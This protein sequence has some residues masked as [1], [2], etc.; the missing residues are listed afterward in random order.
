M[1]IG[2]LGSDYVL[3]SCFRIENRV[4]IIEDRVQ[5]TVFR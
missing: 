2:S 4:P 3:T 5:S 1:D